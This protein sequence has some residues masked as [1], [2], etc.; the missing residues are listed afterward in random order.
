MSWGSWGWD[1][2]CI[3]VDG[4]R[5]VPVASS[6]QMVGHSHRDSGCMEVRSR[7]LVRGTGELPQMLP[8]LADMN[9]D[10]SLVPDVPGVGV[11]EGVQTT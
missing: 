4:Y 2:R 6:A 11:E 8:L 1:T 7:H 10:A 9:L 3:D 5:D